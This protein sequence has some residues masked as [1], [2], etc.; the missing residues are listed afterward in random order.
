MKSSRVSFLLLGPRLV[1]V[2][3]AFLATSFAATAWADP[4]G[5]VGRL[6]DMTGQVWFYAPDAGEWTTAMRNLPLTTGDRVATDAD[7]HAELRIGSTA[8]RLDAG[9]ELEVVRIDD[10]RISLQLHKGSVDARLRSTEAAREF[11]LLSGEGRFVAQRAGRY[12][13]DRQG[14]TSD[15]TVW[16]GQALYEG[17]GSAL[18]VYA[19]QRAEFWLERGAAQYSLTEPV[20]DAF[21]SWSGERDRGDEGGVGNRYV[22]PEMTG[23]EDLDR[24]GRWEQAPEY[25]VVWVPRAVPVGWAPYRSGRWAWVSPWGW[26]WVDEQPWGFAP[27]H[28]GRWAMHRNAWCWVPG[29]YV[30][31]PVYAPALV[32]WVG[33]PQFSVSV[34]VGHAAPAVGWFPL[35]PREVYVPT[36][37]VSPGYVR[38]VNATHVTNIGN[39]ATIV[40]SPQQ[41]VMNTDYRNRHLPHA[42]TVVPQTVMTRRQPVA[43]V[44]AQFNTAAVQ[45]QVAAQSARNVVVS[46][47]PAPPAF[48]DPVRRRHGGGPDA[49]P[50]SAA[51]PVGAA[52]ASPPPGVAAAP[53]SRIAPPARGAFD[54]ELRGR[55]PQERE[56][57]RGTARPDERA[58][59]MPPAVMPAPQPVTPPPAVATRA[60]APAEASRPPIPAVVAA[61]AVPQVPRVQA[62]QAPARPPQGVSPPPAAVARPPVEPLL[63]PAPV[64]RPAP[65]EQRVVPVPALQ[66][67]Q[68]PAMRNRPEWRGPQAPD[69]AGGPRPGSDDA[70]APGREDR[71]FGRGE[72]PQR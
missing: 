39:L 32:G 20:R 23:A 11:E 31:R 16:D 54:G 8:V 29:T 69:A 61:P 30:R 34:S 38:Q 62:M 51:A 64:A 28:Y 19:G 63:V 60:P 52:V 55:T 36:Y 13:F 56:R 26:T 7:G 18:T 5:R 37:R 42:L 14:D 43:P 27:F 46:A 21:A 15:V 9:T 48:S 4:P 17:P 24:Y 70:R 57:G 6:G 35:A 59:P 1:V 71:S 53:P 44:A 25:G 33:G 3:V 41:A 45:Q 72:R 67:Q 10:E 65:A 12:R 2:L 47:P 40:N 58:V 66:S 49:P 50:R 68:P 22:S